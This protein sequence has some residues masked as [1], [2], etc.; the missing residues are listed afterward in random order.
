MQTETMLKTVLETIDVPKLLKELGS[1][2][3]E[4]S[5]IIEL[6]FGFSQHVPPVSIMPPGD[7]DIIKQRFTETTWSDQALVREEVYKLADGNSSHWFYLPKDHD[8]AVING[9]QPQTPSDQRLA[10]FIRYRTGETDQIHYVAESDGELVIPDAQIISALQGLPEGE[11]QV[12][13]MPNLKN[14]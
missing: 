14:A 3:V 6:P 7:V 1:W 5:P 11:V 9:L 2:A 12:F 4:L 13:A 10:D 8:W